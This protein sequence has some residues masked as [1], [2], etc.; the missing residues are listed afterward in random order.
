MI[1]GSLRSLL[2]G[3]AV[4]AGLIASAGTA[5]AIEY[6]F[7]ELNIHLDTTISAG[8]S[9]R[10]SGRDNSLLPTSNGGPLQATDPL[11]DVHYA[12]VPTDLVTGPGV[13]YHP[14]NIITPP[15]SL[16]GS[17]NTDD[18]RLNFDKWD[19]TSGVVKM[20]N[21][22]SATYRNYHFFGR[23]ASYYDFVL[24]DSGS[25]ARS[26]LVDGKADAA[27]DIKLLDLYGSADYDVGGMPL[28]VRAG[29]Q[30]ISWGE[31]TFIQNGINSFNPIDVSAVRRP[32]AELKEFF[33]PV[34]A[35]D[36]S[37]GLPYNLSLEAFY[38][39]KWD[40]F[41]LDRPGTPFAS[42]DVVATGS[43]VGGNYAATSFLT[44]GPGGNIMN[45][46]T[47]P[48]AVN[49]VFNALNASNPYKDCSGLGKSVYDYTKYD[50]TVAGL[51]GWSVGDTERI[52]LAAG[53]SSVVQRDPD[54]YAK[55][56]GQWGLAARWYSEDLNNTEFGVYFSNT[57]SRLPIASERVRVDPSKSLWQSYLATSGTSSSTTRGLGYAG[58]NALN[59][60]NSTTA[61]VNGQPGQLYGVPYGLTA[62]QVAQMNQTAADTNGI[63]AAA[64]TMAENY[65]ASTG[66]GGGNYA[67]VNA[68]AATSPFAGGIAGVS[69]ISL[70]LTTTAGQPTTIQQGSILEATIV[71]CAL[72]AMQSTI[73]PDGNGGYTAALTDGAQTIL[74]SDPNNPALGLYLEYPENIKMYG[75]SFNTTV[76]TWGVQGEFSFRPN[77]PMQ[78]DTDQLT[79]AA[80]NNAC[81]FEMLLG[82]TAYNAIIPGS[83]GTGLS[84][85]DTYGGKCGSLGTGASQL[86]LPGY[87]RSRMWTAQMGTTATYSNSNSIVEATGADLGILVTEVGMVYTPDAP[88]ET[89]VTTDP[90]T[91]LATG[92]GGGLRWANVCTTGT[93][94][95]LGGFLSLASRDGCRPTTMSWGYV[96]L[97]QLQYNNAFGTAVTLSPSIAFSH[98][99]SGNT[100]A[101][102]SNYRQGRKSINLAIN[103]TYQSAWKAGV[104]YTNF[105]G[106]D[107]YNNSGDLDYAAVNISYAF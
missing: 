30:V 13:D 28:N 85:P 7:G 12:D 100:A 49:A 74:A 70:G 11:H 16:Q 57:H 21:D 61:G 67:V 60:A 43:G 51:G 62:A 75:A 98:D 96:L 107:K 31:S 56:S 52:R 83:H 103:A 93:D 15:T 2:L 4:T 54:R 14:L 58:C 3:S 105:F 33:I 24:A 8:A 95:P 104:S 101:P 81:T 66:V 71:N 80:L 90:V 53:D 97:G 68:P 48:N 86:D 92:T 72:I 19:M 73:V 63:F 36:A 106:S 34:W 40:T 87:V 9:I 79:I 6:T 102:Y 35:V 17:I 55:N 32:G 69:L 5:N 39:L 91:H 77:A 46:C 37:I 59:G 78:L 22:L 47:S 1:K 27:R 89:H 10:T 42:S 38:Q 25:Y 82:A 20:T 41:A 44:G 26:N 45:N 94:L 84:N 50:N 64:E 23:L 65:Y 76:G 18:G 88:A 99:V 29:K